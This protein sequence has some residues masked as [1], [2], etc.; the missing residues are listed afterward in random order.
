MTKTILLST[1]ALALAALSAPDAVAQPGAGYAEPPPPIRTAPQV[2]R[3]LTLGFDLGLGSMD[4][5]SSLA[6]CDG[7]DGDQAAGRLGFWIGAMVNPRLA[8]ML[9]GSVTGQSLD[10]NGDQTLINSTGM[11]AAK[12]WVSRRLWLKAGLGF[13]SLTISD[14]FGDQELGEGGAGMLGIGFEAVH[15]RNFALDISL[16]ATSST[17]DDINEE[18]STGTLNLGFNWY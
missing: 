12:L 13:A 18:I 1:L 6:V 10:D 3:G 9:H 15:S 17:Y 16:T 5:E 11:I 7:C 2:R 8:L 4:S 14:E